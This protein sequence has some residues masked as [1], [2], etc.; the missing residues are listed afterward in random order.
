MFNIRNGVLSRTRRGTR[1]PLAIG[2]LG[3]AFLGL[4]LAQRIDLET[5]PGDQPGLPNVLLVGDSIAAGYAPVVRTLLDGQANVHRLAMGG[6]STRDGLRMIDAGLGRTKWAVIHFN[7][8][9]NDLERERGAPRVPPD[10][11]RRNLKEL[12]RR[13]ERTGARLIWASTTPVPEGRVNS[14]RNSRD[15]PEYNRVAEEIM[16]EH[17]IPVNDLYRFALPRLSVLQRKEDVHFNPEGS[18][19]LA[20][21]VARS[22][23]QAVLAAR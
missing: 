7:W 13:F 6:G 17:Q 15:V 3:V 8:G 12:V 20:G 16:R 19:A 1:L 22:V 4:A 23:R 18:A 14:P 10:P 9:L 5:G 2:A 21:E 11:Y